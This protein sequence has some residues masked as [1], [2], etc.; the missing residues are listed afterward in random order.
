M[1]W[2]KPTRAKASGNPKHKINKRG[3]KMGSEG[4]KEKGRQIV[5]GRWTPLR[6][7]TRKLYEDEP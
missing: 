6:P 3:T 5:S 4:Q 2:K 7:K 1:N